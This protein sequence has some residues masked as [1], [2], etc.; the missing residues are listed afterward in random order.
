MTNSMQ[1]LSQKKTRG[2]CCME[3]G[4]VISRDDVVGK[5]MYICNKDN[6]RDVASGGAL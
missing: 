2:Y 4:R 1:G 3:L 5:L 6:R